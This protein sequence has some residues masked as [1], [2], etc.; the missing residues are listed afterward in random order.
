[1]SRLDRL[2]EQ[3]PDL[4]ISVID[5][6]AKVDPTDTYKYTE[7]LIKTL[8][9]W[10][11]S[12]DDVQLHIGIDFFGEENVETLNEFEIHSKSKRIKNSDISTYDG[13]K[14]M[15]DQVKIAEE[16]LKQ[17]ELEKQTLKIHD[18]DTWLVLTPLSFEASKVYGS[19]TKWCTTQERYWENYL[20][21]HRLI[22][23]IN[24]KTDTKVA[25]SRDFNEGKFQ[26]W[27]ADDS[28]VSPM[29]VDFIP[30][31]IFL[32]IRKELQKEQRTI[33]L[34]EGYEPKDNLSISNLMNINSGVDQSNILDRIRRLMGDYVPNE[35]RISDYPNIDIREGYDD[36]MTY[37]NAGSRDH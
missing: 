20:K 15:K 21:T 19:N 25:F 33:D 4:N 35:R 31:D 2:K 14:D 3:H 29:Y 22:Y 12:I 5:I 7:F 30:D 24:K 16:I 32:K 27:T 17:K 1:M 10:Y 37:F 9:K 23:C 6:I 11:S 36:Y 18:D 13:F 8:K 26:S 28:E 34:I